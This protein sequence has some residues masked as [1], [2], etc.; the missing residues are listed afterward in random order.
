MSV[1]GQERKNTM[2]SSV[3]EIIVKLSTLSAFY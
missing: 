1:L 2:F 3:Y